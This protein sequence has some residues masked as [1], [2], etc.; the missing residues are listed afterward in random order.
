[1]SIKA[2]AQFTGLHWTTVKQIEK[3]YLLKKHKK[4]S[5]KNARYLGIDEVY[6]GRTLGYITVVRD[7]ESGAVLFIG[8][9]KG[10]DALKAFERRIRLKAKQI[11]AVTMDMSNAY[12]AWLNKVLPQ[13]EIIYDHFHVI[14]LMNE[15]MD[16]LRRNTMNKLSEE[17]KKELKG[18]RFLLLRNQE[19][20]S[21]DATK[22][23]KKLC[24]EF[25]DLGTTSM[26]KE[27]LRNIYKM[28]CY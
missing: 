5:L 14:K 19:N 12:S 24:V 10:G 17:Q 25:E 11:K 27:F 4:P 28:A 23:L 7:L 3:T 1:M 20:L 18:K 13:A 6:L 21:E 16:N 22:E 15:R 9:G 8:K 26:M 2:V